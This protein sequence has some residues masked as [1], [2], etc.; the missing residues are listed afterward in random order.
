[1]T[2]TSRNQYL[3]E[4]LLQ[5]DVLNRPT[6]SSLDQW[7]YT[8]YTCLHKGGYDT[9][10]RLLAGFSRLICTKL[11]PP[12]SDRGVPPIIQSM[13]LSAVDSYDC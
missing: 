10:F 9:S 8:K 13:R 7:L 3:L 2:D 5:C 11:G 6:W 4:P 1:M 12:V